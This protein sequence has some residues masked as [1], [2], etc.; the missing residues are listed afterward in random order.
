ME[1]FRVFE[2]FKHYLEYLKRNGIA[3]ERIKENNYEFIE[4]DARDRFNAKE[5]F[6]GL[7]NKWLCL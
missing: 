5:D 7:C 3:F 2:P 1:K 4:F 6:H